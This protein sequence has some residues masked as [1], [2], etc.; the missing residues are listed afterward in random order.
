MATWVLGAFATP[1]EMLTAARRLRA[2]GVDALDGHGPYPIEGAEDALGLPPSPVARI[3]LVA[4]VVGAVSG[5]L[6]QWLCNG[7]DYPLD[8]GGRPLHSPPANIP[9]T[10]ELA[11]LCA[12]L[13]AFAAVVA[14]SG[15]PLPWHPVFA[16]DAFRSA[17]VDAFWLS[18][19]VDPGRED[20]VRALLAEAGAAVHVVEEPS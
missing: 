14:L 15:L 10:F 16:C 13:A 5:Y 20:E 6:L 19:A 11:V 4:A 2:A 7:V 3:V 9:I 17:S 8:V 1:D 12:A 18:A